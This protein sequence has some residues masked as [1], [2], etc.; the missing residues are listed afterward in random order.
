[1][2]TYTSYQQRQNKCKVVDF[3]TC[4]G[5]KKEFIN[6][7]DSFILNINDLVFRIDIEVCIAKGVSWNF[8]L[9][10]KNGMNVNGF[11]YSSSFSG[12]F[13]SKEEIVNYIIL[14]IYETAQRIGEINKR[15][16]FN[17][18]LESLKS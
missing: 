14:W 12:E 2:K 15:N 3:L 1:M 18:K 17:K 11:P 6:N 10:D 4:A 9:R 8:Y 13:R 16:E 7:N 5:F